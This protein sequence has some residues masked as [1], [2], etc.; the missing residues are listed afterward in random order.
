[1]GMLDSVIQKILSDRLQSR[2]LD[3]IDARSVRLS[4]AEKAFDLELMLDGEERPL[5]ARLKYEVK[6]DEL[7]IVGVETDKRWITEILQLVLIAK[8]GHFPLPGGM[9]GMLVKV[10]I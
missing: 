5:H 7:H 3:W 2:G 9:V 6:D 8:G 4:K 10:L 1:M